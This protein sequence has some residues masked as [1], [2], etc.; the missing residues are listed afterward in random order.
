MASY[1]NRA[2]TNEP[3]GMFVYKDGRR[4]IYK[5]PYLK[6]GRYINKSDIKTFS[7]FE[8]RLSVSVL[9]GVLLGYTLEDNYII[10]VIVGAIVYI[11]STLVMIL[12]Y[13]PQLQVAE[14]FKKQSTMSVLTE[15]ANNSPYWRLFVVVGLSA[16][17]AIFTYINANNQGYT[18]FVLYGN[19]I[20][21]GISMLYS[22]YTIVVLIRKITLKP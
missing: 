19:Y 9:I 11:I 12:W 22:V 14:G 2:S 8:M 13:L 7:L 16:A 1:N 3:R 21:A 6:K 15:Q 5:P 4:Y 18:G 10:G 20:L 17:L